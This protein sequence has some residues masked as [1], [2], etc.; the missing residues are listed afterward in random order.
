[1]RLRLGRAVILVGLRI[2]GCPRLALQ[3]L[4]RP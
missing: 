2:S 4:V 3:P 1:M